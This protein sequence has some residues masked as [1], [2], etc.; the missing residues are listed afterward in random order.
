MEFAITRAVG[1]PS[2]IAS[3]L[4]VYVRITWFC[5]RGLRVGILMTTVPASACVVYRPML[6]VSGM[7]HVLRRRAKRKASN[8]TNLQT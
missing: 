6:G 7:F 8:L 3:L 2:I 5:S 4:L 1:R